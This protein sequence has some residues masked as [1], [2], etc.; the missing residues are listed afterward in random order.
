MDEQSHARSSGARTRHRG[1]RET[2]VVSTAALIAAIVMTWPLASDLGN[3]GRTQNSG[4]ARFAVWNVA[5]VAHALT[6]DPRG[7]F[8]ANI[9]HPH[10]AAL[11]FSEANIGAGTLAVPVWVATRNPFAAHNSV[12]L[13]AFAASVVFTWLLARHLTGD[14][15]AAATAAVLFAF[16]PYVFAHT[17]HIQL[18]MIAGIP[19]CMLMFHRLADAPSFRRGLWLGLALGAQA[20]SCAYYGISVGLTIGYATLFLAWYRRLWTSRPYWLAIG[21]AA[22][23]SIAVVLPFFLPYLEIQEET[24]FARSLDDA[25]QWSAYLRSY[26]ASGAHAHYWLLGLIRD[27]NQSVLFPGFLSIALGL[28]GAG[29]ALG[30]APHRGVANDRETALLYGSVALLTFWATL[31]PRAGLYT[32]FYTFIP[33]FSFLRAPERMGIVVML[34]LAVLAA[35]AVRALRDRF[36]RQRSA[37]A[38]IVCAAALLEL[39]DIPFDWRK[40]EP[41]PAAYRVLA[42]MPRGAHVD[43]PF[44]DRR[45]DFH[46]HSRYMLDSTVHWQP[47]VNGYSDHIPADFR[48]IAPVLAT[49][50]SRESFQVMRDRRVRYL[51]I[52]RNRY[53]RAAALEVEQRLQAFVDHLRALAD[54]GDV[55]IYEIVSWPR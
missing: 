19:L 30:R 42:A 14:G 8:D 54:D 4:D 24:G 2:V 25:R 43:F 6:T 5:W 48:Q 13:F 23:T 52:H 47:L 26:L 34:C 27:W 41:I 49:F 53:G 16:C 17:P 1:I 50:P 51:A 12:V 55:A 38:A 37:I 21:V 7:L 33:V 22:A 3:L 31:G 29:I 15:G 46:I 40:A 20:L 32:V 28:A 44:Y 18:L 9:F 11:A 39:N 45:I 10:R 36:P 35:F